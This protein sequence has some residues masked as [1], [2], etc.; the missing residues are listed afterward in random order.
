MFPPE[1]RS[2][3]TQRGRI[4]FSLIVSFAL[5]FRFFFSPRSNLSCS[6]SFYTPQP[7]IC[8]FLFFLFTPVSLYS[9]YCLQPAAPR[10]PS[11]LYLLLLHF[12]LSFL[13]LLSARYPIPAEMAPTVLL[14]I[15]SAFDPTPVIFNMRC[16]AASGGNV[17]LLACLML[18][19]VFGL[20]DCGLLVFMKTLTRPLNTVSSSLAGIRADPHEHQHPS[21]SSGDWVEAGQSISGLT[22]GLQ[23]ALHLH[24]STQQIGTLQSTGRASPHT[25]PLYVNNKGVRLSSTGSSCYVALR[26]PF[27]H[28]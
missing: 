1:F 9:L 20:C 12:P 13:P 2:H 4:F 23:G 21:C 24:Q 25:S 18:F 5:L 19:L 7:L 17:R 10:S 26:K 3:F 22:L 8:I 16:S 28:L 6:F 14:N 11:P 15:C 27:S